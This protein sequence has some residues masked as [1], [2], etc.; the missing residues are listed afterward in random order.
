MQDFEFQDLVDECFDQLEDALDDLDADLDID[1]TGGVLTVNIEAGGTII[2][3]RQV[4]NHEIWI[5]AKSGGY[6]LGLSADGEWFCRTTE[7]N[8]WQISS[9]VFSEQLGRDVALSAGA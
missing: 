4:A 9:R 3:S 1:I 8:L 7:E 5:A 6:H 2:F